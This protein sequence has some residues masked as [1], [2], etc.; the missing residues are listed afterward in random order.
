[1]RLYK[2]RAYLLGSVNRFQEKHHS[3]RICRNIAS[4]F[5]TSHYYSSYLLDLFCIPAIEKAF[6]DSLLSESEEM[7]EELNR[8][9]EDIGLLTEIVTSMHKTYCK[10][11]FTN[12]RS[13][14][15]QEPF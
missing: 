15:I 3:K 5:F 11:F 13:S 9:S 6:L 8:Q 1:M 2:V 14:K 4:F 10:N 7:K 12:M